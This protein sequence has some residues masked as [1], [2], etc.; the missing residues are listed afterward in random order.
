MAQNDGPISVTPSEI[1]TNE[2]AA[3]QPKKFGQKE[4]EA[5]VEEL[6]QKLQPLIAKYMIKI[7]A[8]FDPFAEFD[9]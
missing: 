6:E 3:I 7:D 8:E 5:R 9:D 1:K 2:P 4:I